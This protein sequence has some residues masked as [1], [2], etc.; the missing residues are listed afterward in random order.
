MVWLVGISEVKFAQT[1]KVSPIKISETVASS[2]VSMHRKYFWK[3]WVLIQFYKKKF[4]FPNKYKLWQEPTS[5]Q[6][7]ST[8][9]SSIYEIAIFSWLSWKMNRFPNRP[10]SQDKWVSSKGGCFGFFPDYLLK[11]Q[12]EYTFCPLF[13]IPSSFLWFEFEHDCWKGQSSEFF[14]WIW[15]LRMNMTK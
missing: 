12:L 7:T 13:I 15:E 9:P 5:N 2:L 11:I 3:K 1:G 14:N 10:T 8:H 6:W 4:S